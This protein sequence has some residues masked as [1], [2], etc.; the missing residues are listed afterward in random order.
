M[1]SPVHKIKQI[2]N[3]DVWVGELEQKFDKLAQ[4]IWSSQQIYRKQY[5]TWESSLD[6]RSAW[7]TGMLNECIPFA[8]LDL[9]HMRD[10][11][12]YPYVWQKAFGVTLTENDWQ[13]VIMEYDK[14]IRFASLHSTYATVEAII[15]RVCE[16]TDAQ[17]YSPK[18]SIGPIT[19]HLLE[20]LELTSFKNLYKLVRTIRNSIHNNGVYFPRDGKDCTIVWN[21][22]YTFR[23]GETVEILDWDFLIQ[24]W[25]EINE[26]IT[27]IVLH[28]KIATIPSIPRKY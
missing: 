21:G 28:P 16:A 20:I 14:H 11:L 17:F 13:Q 2:E 15:R 10:N 9:W 18:K 27:A 23:V 8:L 4:E 12:T 5:P 24:H 25:R 6:A 22:D 19:N 26:A 1:T 3:I 7:F